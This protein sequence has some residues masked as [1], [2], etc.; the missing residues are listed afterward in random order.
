MFKKIKKIL[1]SYKNI[2]N[3]FKKKES[4]NS[5]FSFIDRSEYN[6]SKW[7]QNIFKKEN[8]HSLLIDELEI[9][10]IKSDIS[11][12]TASSLI[13]EIKNQIKIKKITKSAELLP[14]V[15]KIL[16]DFYQKNDTS[17]KKKNIIGVN[18]P[19]VYLFVGV[20]GVG[21]TST[22]GKLAFKF[23]NENKKIL[24][25]AG[26][27]FRTGAVEQLKQWGKE[28]DTEVFYKEG[29]ITPSSL[30]FEALNYAKK[31][32]FDVVLCDTSG[33]LENKVNLMKELEK[34]KKV[35]DKQINGIPYETFLILDSM[36]GQS[37]LKQFEIFNKTVSLT[38]IILTKFDGISKGG[39]ILA[40]KQLYNLPIKYITVG[41]K[42]N[43]LM[44]FDINEYIDNLFQD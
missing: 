22:I 43:D 24:L 12:S 16:I 21:K 38:N 2:P 33:R 17:I 7:R 31:N 5:I 44:I 4:K 35:I 26:D 36:T 15:K 1:K 40:I 14:L 28:S 23:K 32:K 6:F 27:T 9:L 29:S 41:E 3:F 37:N 30:F 19:K 34:I 18:Q 8:I 10:F 42:I 25:V 11:V 20:N 39:F 13:K